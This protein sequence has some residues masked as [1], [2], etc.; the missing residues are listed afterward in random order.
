MQHQTSLTT[1]KLPSRQGRIHRG[2]AK[3][4]GITK[5]P[6]C[7][8]ILKTLWHLIKS[9]KR[10]Y[11]STFSESNMY[12][13]FHELHKPFNNWGRECRGKVK[14][15]PFSQASIQWTLVKGDWKV[16]PS[17]HYGQNI[18]RLQFNVIVN[19]QQDLKQST[20]FTL[21]LWPLFLAPKIQDMKNKSAFM[22][23]L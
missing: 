7:F 13:Y 15:G 12:R 22:I 2:L 20:N 16:Y 18:L 5:C 10:S 1:H 14:I 4:Q 19:T 8:N 17:Q 3:W 21:P 6:T 11:F 9:K 23:T